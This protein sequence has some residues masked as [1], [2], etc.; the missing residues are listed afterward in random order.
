MCAS[1]KVGELRIHLKK[2]TNPGG[3]GHNGHCCDGKW[4]AC[5][6]NG[7]DHYFVIC[8]DGI[9]RLILLKVFCLQNRVLAKFRL[10]H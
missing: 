9:K 10:L 1:A 2:Y 6:K 7:C 4:G 5:Q 8:V 3:K